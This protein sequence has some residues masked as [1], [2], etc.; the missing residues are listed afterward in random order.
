MK[1]FA[2]DVIPEKEVYEDEE[3]A[4]HHTRPG[5]DHQSTQHCFCG[6][7]ANKHLDTDNL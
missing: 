7:H 3:R 6:D 4:D 5:P 1:N 2:C